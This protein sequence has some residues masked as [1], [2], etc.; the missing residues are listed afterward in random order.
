M[1]ELYG[2]RWPDVDLARGLI[3]VRRSYDRD[4]TKSKKVRHVRINKQLGSVL[5]AWRDVCP[6]GPL[7]LVFPKPDGTLRARERPPEGFDKR[8]AEAR[9]HSI[10]FHDLRHT[11]ASLLVMAGVSLRAVQTMLGHSTIQVTEKYAHLAPDFQE[12]EAERLKLD[13]QVGLGNLVALDGGR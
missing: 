7:G 3:T 2:L 13:V 8:L 10:R 11:A 1:G 6:K 5:K 4:F 12:R 9:C